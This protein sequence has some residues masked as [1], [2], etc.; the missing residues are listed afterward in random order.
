MRHFP[1]RVRIAR[2]VLRWHRLPERDLEPRK[3]VPDA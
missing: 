3:D 2:I 1:D